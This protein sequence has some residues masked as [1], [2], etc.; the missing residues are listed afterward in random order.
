MSGETRKRADRPV[1]K[2]DFVKRPASEAVDSMAPQPRNHP[3]VQPRST[4][5]PRTSIR[6]SS[7]IHS[8]VRF[9]RPVNRHLAFGGAVHRCLGSH[10]ARRELRVALREWH[11]RIPEYGL[12]PGC[13]VRYRPPL[14]FVPDLQ[15]S[16]PVS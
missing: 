9:D 10:L 16:W 14:R 11:R 8:K 5:A 4:S 1:M 2:L 7:P 13:E 6:P 12:T 15:L 3:L